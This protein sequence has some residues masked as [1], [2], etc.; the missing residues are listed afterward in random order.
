M[1]ATNTHGVINGTAALCDRGK[2]SA[3]RGDML[4]Q[5]AVGDL[6][7]MQCGAQGGALTRAASHTKDLVMDGGLNETS[8]ELP[9][10]F[11]I[12]Q[13]VGSCWFWLTAH[14]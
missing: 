9:A 2:I 12:C 14:I 10:G 6:P 8:L 7:K 11:A 1:C 5:Y 4:E 13:L 3:E